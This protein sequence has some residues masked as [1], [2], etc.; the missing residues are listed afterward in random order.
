MQDLSDFQQQSIGFALRRL[1]A[2]DT[3]DGVAFKHLAETMGRGLSLSGRDGQSLLALSG[4]KWADMPADL[5]KATRAKVCEVLDVP[6][7]DS[8]TAKKGTK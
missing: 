6:P 4:V 1:M 2:A 8:K 5:E 7:I 3:F